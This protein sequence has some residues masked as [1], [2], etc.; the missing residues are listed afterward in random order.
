[1]FAQF[2]SWMRDIEWRSGFGGEG[3]PSFLE[4]GGWIAVEVLGVE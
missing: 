2:V 3:R 1:M 4:V